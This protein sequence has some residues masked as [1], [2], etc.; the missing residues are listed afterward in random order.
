MVGAEY[1]IAVVQM[2]SGNDVS[3]NLRVAEEA[4]E[5]AAA[6][7]AQVVCFPEMMSQIVAQGE[8]PASESI[9]NGATAV[10][11]KR[12]AYEK[13]LYIHSGSF[14]EYIRGEQRIYN[15][16]MLI[17]SN[18]ELI[19]Q[20]RKIHTF[21]V[22]LPDGTPCMESASV[23]AGSEMAVAGTP[24]GKWG[25]AICYDLRF[26]ELFRK[27]ALAGAQV[28]FLPANFTRPTGRDHWEVLLRARA[29]ENGCYLVAADQ[30]GVKP[31][32]ASFGTSMIID[33]W[34]N[35]IARASGDKPEI[36]Y[37]A[38][39]PAR[40][41]EVRGQLPVLENRRADVYGSL[42]KDIF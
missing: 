9:E 22:T 3:R 6:A 36:I 20:Y 41:G 33:P 10:L 26:P 19:A 8:A 16:S 11:L 23:K 28:I 29:I 35:V 31:D 27:M 7:G 1:K 32:F 25:M 2:D 4:I 18:G 17:D 42:E 13:G 37:A 12:K 38:I 15:T 14:P 5:E 40:V 30:C 39:D 21:D 34:G 24:F